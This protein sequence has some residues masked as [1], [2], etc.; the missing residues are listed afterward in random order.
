MIKLKAF[1]FTVF[2][3]A[4]L[5]LAV[6]VS[7][8]I[9]EWNE[10]FGGVCADYGREALQTSDGGYII[11][12]YTDTTGVS[13][14]VMLIKTDS[15]GTE[16]W[17][18]TFGGSDNDRAFSVTETNDGGFVM[19][20]YTYS[21][22][23]GERDV[24]L[25]K[26][27]SSGNK[28]WDKT[29]GGT[30]GE[31]GFHVEQTSDGGFIIVGETT[32]YGAGYYDLWL[33]KTDGTGNKTWDK[34]FGGTAYD[35]GESV[36][37]TSDG[38][39]IIT[40]C[41]A[42]FSEG[43]R[44]VW[45][46][47]T[48]SSGNETWSKNF[49]GPS[50]DEGSAVK[51][52]PDG[53]YIIA[54]RKTPN[55]SAEY[56]D[57]LIRTD[58]TGN[59]I[60][61]KTFG[62]SMEDALQAVEISPRGGFI[63][64][65][66]TESHGAGESDIWV[67]E[68]DSDGNMM[69]EKLY[70]GSYSEYSY[71]IQRTTYGGCIICGST[72]SYGNGNF[73]FWVIKNTPLYLLSPNG[74][75]AWQGGSNNTIKWDWDAVRLPN[76]YSI[77]Y[78]INGGSTY[79]YTIAS[80][81]SGSDSTYN[82]TLPLLTTKTVRVQVKAK[83]PG[84]TTLATACSRF[85][86]EIDA[87][88]P[89]DISD[90]QIAQPGYNYLNITWTV[91][92]DDGTSGNASGY[93]IRYSLSPINVSNWA[94]ANQC[95]DEPVP[96]APGDTQ[97]F[98]ISPLALETEYHVAM[99]TKDNAGNWS[100]LSNVTSGATIRYP[101]LAE[102]QHPMFHYDLA[103]SGRSPYYGYLN[104]NVKWYYWTGAP[105]VSSPIIGPDGTIYVVSDSDSLFSFE[106][107]GTRKWASYVGNTTKST[108]AIT[109]DSLI[110]VCNG[111]GTFK[112]YDY[113]GSL[114]WSYDVSGKIISSPAV[115]KDGVIYFGS[116]NDT[117]YAL[118]GNGVL[119]WKFATQ[120]EVIGS[121]A[122]SS[123]GVIYVGSGD[124]KFYAVNPDG[125]EAWAASMPDGLVSSPAVDTITGIIYVG[126]CD[127]KIYSITTNGMPKDVFE[128][129]SDTILS[130]PAIGADGKIYI[131]GSNGKMY[132][133]TSDLDLIWE[134]QTGGAIE[135]SP[136]ID[137]N[138]HVYVGS[139]DGKIYCFNGS[140]STVIWSIQTWDAVKS[141]PAIGANSCIYVGSNDYR[142]YAFGPNTPVEVIS[143]NGGEEWEKSTEYNIYWNTTGSTENIKLYYS[144]N[145]GSSWQVISESETDDGTYPWITP[146]INCNKCRVKV[147]SFDA[148]GDS[149]VD[150]SDADFTIGTVGIEDTPGDRPK[151]FFISRNRPNPFV[152]V[153]EIDYGLPRD[154]HVKINLYNSTGQRVATLADGMQKPGYHSIKLDAGDLAN[155]IYFVKFAM[156]EFRDSRKITVLR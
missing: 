107:D 92:G 51:Q 94:S 124:H 143:P 14:E 32:S 75:E 90:L 126:S 122:I 125:S 83:G 85:S 78:S 136:V 55:I 132:A 58:G 68:T 24:W 111:N 27:D 11:C 148:G 102:S 12:G 50:S 154:S 119:K 134:Y 110:Y 28:L 114:S 73:D 26:T 67:F 34:T 101:V 2:G 120:G 80:S 112:A 84:G 30:G 23:A 117:L 98:C 66:Y 4:G 97:C 37:Q 96:Y 16:I 46:I 146:V 18:K 1:V 156:G 130:S 106:I 86:F 54:G 19:V 56:D 113:S 149:A 137:A 115:G 62:G 150:I 105:V 22:G 36:Q 5:F 9:S 40:G 48:N 71:S 69:W 33:I 79:P 38:G 141:S 88:P 121:P 104:E 21:Y 145:S 3:I 31:C 15:T 72:Y 61:D 155:G 93:D 89:D 13:T 135:S 144:D 138:G 45:L 147:V 47:K 123:H 64:A 20:G 76:S 52:T 42:S 74:W 57:W 7:A 103:H 91:P 140:D 127:G 77:A 49:G 65:G 82:W 99:K 152:G 131:G 153:T 59:K 129:G 10:T 35:C 139:D 95:S 151:T 53:G 81:V 41:T 60:W 6:N 8:Q 29:F 39:F 25:I 108:P 133:L 70:G 100:D 63:A 44:D 109:I 87:I 142:V 128:A 17:S 116:T 43:G 118:Y